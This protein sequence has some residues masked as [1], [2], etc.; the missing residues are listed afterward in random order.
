MCSKARND[1]ATTKPE[2]AM[3]T[4]A[5]GDDIIDP[6]KVMDHAAAAR[7]RSFTTPTA[8]PVQHADETGSDFGSNIAG[9]MQ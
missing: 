4:P 5:I 9:F 8:R 6:S 2:P 1:V 3:A 7:A